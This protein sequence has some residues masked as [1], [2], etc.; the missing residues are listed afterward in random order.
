[1][2]AQLCYITIYPL[3]NYIGDMGFPHICLS[4]LN[5]KFSP[6]QIPVKGLKAIH[7]CI[8]VPRGSCLLDS[9]GLPAFSSSPVH[10]LWREGC[11]HLLHQKKLLCCWFSQRQKRSH[12]PSHSAHPLLASLVCCDMALMMGLGPW[13]LVSGHENISHHFSFFLFF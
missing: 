3:Y 10:V 6:S 12:H 13:Y 7:G 11:C 4:L 2:G 9:L 5:G 1:M 8:H